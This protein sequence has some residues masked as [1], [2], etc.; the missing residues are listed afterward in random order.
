MVIRPCK[1]IKQENEPHSD[2][3]NRKLGNILELAKKNWNESKHL[4]HWD[5]IG[6]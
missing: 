1:K 5:L 4:K 2:K 3:T 6:V